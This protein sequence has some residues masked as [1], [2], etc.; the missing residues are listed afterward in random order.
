MNRL[1]PVQNRDNNWPPFSYRNYKPQLRGSRHFMDQVSMKNG[2]KN[3]LDQQMSEY[4]DG[5]WEILDFVDIP[6][7]LASRL[8]D[9]DLAAI[10][11][12][13][14]AKN[15][16]NRLN[17]T[18]CFG[19]V[20]Q[21]LEPLRESKVLEKLDL[22]LVRQIEVPQIFTDAQISDEIVCAIL[23]GILS[24]EGNTFKR[25]YVPWFG[26]FGNINPSERLLQFVGSHD[27]A[28]MNEKNRCAY[29]GSDNLQGLLQLQNVERSSDIIDRC[30]NAIGTNM[31]NALIAIRYYAD[32]RMWI[33]VAERGVILLAVM[34]VETEIDGQGQKILLTGVLVHIVNVLMRSVRQD[35]VIADYVNV[36]M[37][38]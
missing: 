2:M 36:V 8:T 37:V 29:F 26:A 3:G 11:L 30:S 33:R 15:N 27:L 18:H 19:I 35:V 4:Y 7:A 20:G 6:K 1:V 38:R 14:D 23:N 31:L 21:G 32:A 10:L 9:G 25:L 5:G 17:L 12:C 28:F 16:L 13:I 22:G 24:V 34:I